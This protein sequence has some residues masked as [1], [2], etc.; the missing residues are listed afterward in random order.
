M[1]NKR[2]LDHQLFQSS[3]PDFP[4]VFAVFPGTPLYQTAE[5]SPFETEKEYKGGASK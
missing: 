4:C 5:S 2:N 1:F 3:E